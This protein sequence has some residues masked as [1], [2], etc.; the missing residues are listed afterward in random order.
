MCVVTRVCVLRNCEYLGVL[1][2]ATCE[3][4]WDFDAL[5]PGLDGAAHVVHDVV[6]PNANP[7]PHH[8]YEAINIGTDP[9]DGIVAALGGVF[10]AKPTAGTVCVRY[11]SA[12]FC[13]FA[14][15][16][17]RFLAR[18][19]TADRPFQLVVYD[20]A[21]RE[22]HVIQANGGDITRNFDLIATIPVHI[23]LPAGYPYRDS[24]VTCMAVS[25]GHLIF[26][27]GR[28]VR[29]FEL[30]PNGE[31][32]QRLRDVVAT[33]MAL[34]WGLNISEFQLTGVWIDEPT[35][36]L[37]TADNCFGA[38][39]T[40]TIDDGQPTANYFSGRG[41]LEHCRSFVVDSAHDRIYAV[42]TGEANVV[43]VID[44]RTDSCLG[45]RVIRSET[46]RFFP[47][48]AINNLALAFDDDGSVSHVLCSYM[49]PISAGFSS[50]YVR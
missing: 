44:T 40:Y 24:P 50:V 30:F 11:Q 47:K 35:G 4:M 31:F 15:Q 9:C 23:T 27:Q 45:D 6:I 21:R 46:A 29:V 38:I 49:H 36:T 12:W 10:V 1:P 33:H 18:R 20:E 48:Y 8:L 42:G 28:N 2:Q 3:V 34:E 22:F 32:Y 39:S 26:A 14:C 37:Y 25:A 19:P 41:L 5:G 43:H 17:P 16:S 13:I 7:P